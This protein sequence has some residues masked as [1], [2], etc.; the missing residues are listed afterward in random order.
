MPCQQHLTGRKLSG[1]YSHR[2][3]RDHGSLHRGMTLIEVLV[4]LVIVSVAVLALSRS[5]GDVLDAQYQLENK[6]L[7]LVVANNVLA[8]I[9]LAGDLRPGRVEGQTSMARRTWYWEALVQPTPDQ[10]LL[11]VDVG[12]YELSD[13]QTPV[14]VH[15]GFMLP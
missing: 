5:A 7:G 8:E 3:R 1:Y 2:H 4:A 6:T 14:V 10:S 9:Q 12:V 13:S 11:R 15:T